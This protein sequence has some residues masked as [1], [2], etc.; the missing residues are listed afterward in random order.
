MNKEIERKYAIKYIPKNLEFEKVVNIKQSF[1]YKDLNTIIRIR[2]IENEDTKY[3][4]TVKTKL[5]SS[6][7]KDSKISNVCEIENNITKEEYTQLKKG[8]IGNE[9]NKTRIVVP[10]NKELK[11]EIDLYKD[12]LEGLLTA[13]IEFKNEYEAKEFVKPGWLGKELGYK[14]LSNWKLSKMTK[15]EWQAKLP[16]EILENNKK[17]I[18]KLKLNYNL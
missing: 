14:D 5:N 18:Q 15:D 3:V 1:I 16:N 10:I 9:I 11:V 6:L 8:K 12:Y 2:K 7:E 4:Y 17:I 13:E